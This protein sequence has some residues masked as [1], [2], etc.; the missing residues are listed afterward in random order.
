MK[1]WE[2][3]WRWDDDAKRIVRDAPGAEDDVER[4]YG[5]V[6]ETDTGVYPPREADRKLI[7]AAPELVRVLLAI[8]AR[9]CERTGRRLGC[10]AC[11]ADTP[12][13]PHAPDCALDAAL[14]KAGV[15]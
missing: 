1:A 10:P 7:V 8:E 12:I 9:E 15:R 11:E 4:D 3:A 14:R 5:V 13:E 2:E 6:V